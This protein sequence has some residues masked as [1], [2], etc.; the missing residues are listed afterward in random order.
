M[1]ATVFAA[2]AR[3]TALVALG[4]PMPAATSPYGMVWKRIDS[5]VPT[6]AAWSGLEMRETLEA[7]AKVSRELIK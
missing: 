4:L 2:Q 7:K 6:G 3:A 5:S 1:S